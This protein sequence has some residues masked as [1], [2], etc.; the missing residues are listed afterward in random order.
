MESMVPKLVSSDLWITALIG[1]GLYRSEG[2][3]GALARS[4]GSVVPFEGSVRCLRG[5][6]LFHCCG[7]LRGRSCL[8]ISDTVCPNAASGCFPLPVHLLSHWS[9]GTREKVLLSACHQLSPSSLGSALSHCQLFPALRVE[10]RVGCGREKQPCLLPLLQR[11]RPRLELSSGRDL[12][13]H[14]QEDF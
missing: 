12:G 13:A 9:F 5:R 11:L 10:V 1:V 7:A 14:R 6:E 4:P 8:Q 3:L 2:V